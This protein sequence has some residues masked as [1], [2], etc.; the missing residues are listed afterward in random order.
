[1]HSRTGR[2][3]SILLQSWITERDLSCLRWMSMGFESLA[4]RVIKRD[5][6]VFHLEIVGND[7]D[8]FQ[9]KF[10]ARNMCLVHSRTDERN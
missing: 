6:G 4:L 1:V 2:K 9:T 10:I 5:L 8:R 7:W 3:N